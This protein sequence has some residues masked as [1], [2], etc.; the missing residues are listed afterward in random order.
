MTA[1]AR[2]VLDVAGDP[3]EEHEGEAPLR[4]RRRQAFLDAAE[5]LFLEQG[6]DR[7]SLADI[8][9]RSRGSLATL[10][11]LFGN[12]QGLLQAIA[13]RWRD[14]LAGPSGTLRT[15]GPLGAR[16]MLLAY[17]GELAASMRSARAVSLT[18][19]IISESL[20]DRAFAQQI[21]QDLHAA[22]RREL[23]Q[24]LAA[25]AADGSAEVE[26]PG[27]AA[28]MFMALVFGDS[29]LGVLAG[30]ESPGLE[31]EQ[32]LRRLAPFFEAFRIA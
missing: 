13:T 10:Y 20:R 21:Y 29:L 18:R 30:I 32:M 15:D 28:D 9:G 31:H 27:E 6:Y 4:A 2:D 7:T 24:R 17:A 8:V 23:A 16:T 14:E 5:A 26:E 12:K 1:S 3:P 19:M 22:P 11:A 25:W